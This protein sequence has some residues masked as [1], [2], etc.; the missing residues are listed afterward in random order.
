MNVGLIYGYFAL[1]RRSFPLF[2][3]LKCEKPVYTVQDG[4]NLSMKLRPIDYSALSRQQEPLVLFRVNIT[5]LFV[6]ASNRLS[7][8]FMMTAESSA[9]YR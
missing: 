6:I 7:Q 8:M 1:V 3:C 2:V 4:H 5:R 9:Y